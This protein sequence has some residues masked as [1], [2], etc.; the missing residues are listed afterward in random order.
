L[1]GGRVRAR[2]SAQKKPASG[3]AERDTPRTS[4][5]QGEIPPVFAEIV[6]GL[7]NPLLQHAI[8]E[9]GI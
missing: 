1:N 7:V 9:E 4:P 3:F 2:L 8:A 5:R 6:F